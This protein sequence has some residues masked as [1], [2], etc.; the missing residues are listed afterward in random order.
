VN[1][2]GLGKGGEG[3]ATVSSGGGVVGSG[4]CG[5]EWDGMVVG[6]LLVGFEGRSG[7]WIKIESHCECVRACC[8][9]WIW[10]YCW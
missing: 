6:V 10:R 3:R 1:D 4:R 2:G 9:C 5:A 7:E 8:F